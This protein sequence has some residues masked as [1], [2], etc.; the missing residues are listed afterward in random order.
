MVSEDIVCPTDHDVPAGVI[1]DAKAAWR[2]KAADSELLSLLEDSLDRG[3]TA[4]S[5]YLRFGGAGATLRIRVGANDNGAVLHIETSIGVADT[6]TVERA[7]G[8]SARVTAEVVVDHGIV[9]VHVPAE[10]PRPACHTDWF[11]V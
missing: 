9:R 2:S 7:D 8:G 10:P 5:R 6:F 4:S 3:T 11:R 1:T